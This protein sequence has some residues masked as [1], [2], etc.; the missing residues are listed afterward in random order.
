MNEAKSTLEKEIKIRYSLVLLSA[1]VVFNA[2]VFT[3]LWSWFIVPIFNL[4]FINIP[5]A[6]GILIAV[7]LLKGKKDKK[8]KITAQYLIDSVANIIALFSIGWLITIFIQL[9][10]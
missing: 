10:A 4:P 2:Y 8:K 5:E 7:K 6:I 3:I 9:V 1:V